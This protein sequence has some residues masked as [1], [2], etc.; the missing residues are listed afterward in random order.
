MFKPA[1]VT[2]VAISTGTM[3]RAIL[4]VIGVFA[5]WVLRDLMMVLLTAIVISSF[6]ESSVPYFKRVGIGRV[7]GI[8]ILYV[9]TLGF[10]AGMFYLFAPLLVTEIYNFSTFLASYFPG[11]SFL[12]YFKDEAF[13]GAKDIVSGLSDD[14][15]LASLMLVSKAFIENL[16]GGFVK[17]LSVAFGSIFNFMLIVLISFYLSVQENGIENFLRIILPIQHEEYVVDLWK[18]SR[19]KIALWFKGQLLLSVIITILTYLVL[20]LMGIKYALLLSII[21]GVMELVPY[22]VLVALVPAAA[23]SYLTGGLSSALMVSGAYII[24]HQ[25]EVFLF[26][27]LVIKGVVGLSPIVIILAAI[28]GFELGGFWGAL[29]SIPMTVFIIEL[30]NDMEKKKIFHKNTHA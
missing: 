6:I 27:P 24:I 15:T 19:R 21:A 5:I 22:G 17:T 2:P 7:T 11:V 12:D 18:R 13:S 28:I 10:F 23:F 14:F 20:A 29:I 16:S 1:D 8:V 25:F 26:A 9:L 3:V 4:L 30:M